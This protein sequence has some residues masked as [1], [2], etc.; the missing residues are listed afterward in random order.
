MLALTSLAVYGGGDRDRV[1][2]CER[3]PLRGDLLSA[4]IW[5]FSGQ[6]LST[7]R[8]RSN[9][10]VYGDSLLAET[11][12]G[13]RCWHHVSSDSLL[14]MSE[15]DR[16]TMLR[17]DT[18]VFSSPRPIRQ[19]FSSTTAYSA[20]GH[21]SGKR[22]AITVTGTLEFE[23]SP[24]TGLLIPASGDTLRG[25]SVTRERRTF[26]ATFPDDTTASPV[27]CLV[28]TYRWYDPDGLSSLLPVAMQR[29]VRFGNDREAEP[30]YSMAFLPDRNGH[31][32]DNEAWKTDSGMHTDPEAVA[33]ALR[34][35][36]VSS[37]GRTVRVNVTLPADGL[38]LAVDIIDASGRLYL[39][40]ASMS[41]DVTL[42]CSSLRQ[43]EYIA[44]ISVE[45]ASASPEKRLVI[46]R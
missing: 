9:V 8:G 34:D 42:D 40:Q 12:N 22:F 30:S 28:E 13:R 45:E 27:S 4:S 23:S 32:G 15:E 39:H 36:S 18:A 3:S 35:A 33:S 29:T 6:W 24:R 7:D 21:G 19:G 31:N 14:Y 38:T 10:R 1:F 43:G 20:S 25:I 44:V 11:V 2:P 41:G 46:I 17:L 16:L 5:D 26:T 37:D